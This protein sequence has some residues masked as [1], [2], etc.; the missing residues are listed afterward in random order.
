LLYTLDELGERERE[1]EREMAYQ[2]RE[3][4]YMGS[5]QHRSDAV[6]KRQATCS[7]TGT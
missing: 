3:Y 7:A 2:L 1:R 6:K 4:W 5:T